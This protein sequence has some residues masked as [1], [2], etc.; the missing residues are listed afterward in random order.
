MPVHYTETALKMSLREALLARQQTCF[1]FHSAKAALSGFLQ[2]FSTTDPV[3][4][5]LQVPEQIS[6][7]LPQ[8]ARHMPAQPT[9][10]SPPPPAEPAKTAQVKQ[11]YTFMVG[12]LG[13]WR[14]QKLMLWW[15]LKQTR[16]SLLTVFIVCR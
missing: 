13:R 9:P 3:G 11:E 12:L 15:S 7:H 1:P 16:N 10:V 14:Q 6:A 2:L 4:T 5:L 8:P